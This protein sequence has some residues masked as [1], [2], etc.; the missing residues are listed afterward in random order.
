MKPTRRNLTTLLLACCAAMPAKAKAAEDAPAVVASSNVAETHALQLW[1]PRPAEVWTE[2]LPVGNGRLGAM[3]FGGTAEERLQFNED[4]VW[5]GTP[6]EYQHEG[7]VE[8]LPEIRRLLFEGKQK[9]AEALANKRFM[10]VPLRQRSYQPLG[11]LRLRL[12]G[13]DKAIDYRRDLDLDTAVAAV[14][15]RVDNATYTR[16]TFSSHPD[17]VLVEHLS[18]D[19][20]GSVSFRASL[21]SPHEDFSVTGQGDSEVLLSGRVQGRKDGLPFAARLRVVTQGGRCSV[22]DEGNI[23]VKGADAATLLV[24]AASAFEN[25]QK[26]GGNPEKRSLDSMKAAAGKDFADLRKAHVADHQRLFQRVAIDLGATPEKT[27]ALPT[28]ERIA[29]AD[30]SG[31]PD[32]AELLFQ[33]GRYLLISSSRPGTQAANLQGIWNDKLSPPW[34]SKYTVNINLPM[35]YWPAEVANLPECAEPLF[36]L[37]DDVVISG[38]K[39]AKTHY[40]TRGWVLHHNTDIWRGTAPINNANHGIWPTGGAWLCQHLWEHWRYSGDRKFLAERAYPVLKEA[41]LFFV[42]F[43]IEDPASGALISG[44]SNSPESGGLVMGPTM[45]HQII[46]SL[47]S[48]T[49]QAARILGKDKAFAAQLDKLRTRIAPNKIGKHGQLQEWL[50]DKDN[51]NYHHRHVSH[52]WGVFPGEDITWETPDFMKAAR[53]S[54]IFRGDG[55][56][57]WS[58]G[59]KISLWSRFLDGDHAF[60]LLMN[61]LKLVRENSDE[62]DTTWEGGGTYP[63]LFDAHPPFQIDG[64]FAAT[65]GICEMLVQSHT[66]EIVLLPA[67]PPAWPEGSVKGLRVRGGFEA[68]LAWKDGKLTEATFRSLAGASLKVRLGDH[69]IDLPTRRGESYPFG[70][71]LTR[72]R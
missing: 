7:A 22:D 49:A 43:L 42:D 17:Q 68:D 25:F 18:A 41:S 65:A 34:G 36:S 67:L 26:I 2:A 50:E 13:H 30:K 12:G 59:W 60:Q 10:S 66:G 1:Y 21:T 9:E 14:R 44:P 38:R 16:E 6:H 23:Q 51:P 48:W 57:G 69:V 3:V 70:P 33:Y 40:G 15:Y 19:R 58:L 24:T 56:T 28:D 52:L 29:A 20:P 39:T 31:D 64:N 47:F 71:N 53:Q 32:L 27:A 4:T 63:N 45:D 62:K 8:V 54:L 35:N 5:T 46:R 55:G 37:I 61:Q 11:D 72:L